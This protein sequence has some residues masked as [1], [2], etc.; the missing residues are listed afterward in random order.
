[1]IRPLCVAL[2]LLAIACGKDHA[3]SKPR[4]T[5]S[6]VALRVRA[7]PDAAATPATDA[8]VSPADALGSFLE[9]RLGI[10]CLGRSRGYDLSCTGPERCSFSHEEAASLADRVRALLDSDAAAAP[11]EVTLLEVFDCACE[12]F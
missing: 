6:V 11:A 7:W 2:V 1:M 3:P 12:V 9:E 10:E 8:A 5:G 4:C